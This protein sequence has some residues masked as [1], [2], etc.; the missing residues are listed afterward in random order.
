MNMILHCVTQ[1]VGK[2]HQTKTRARSTRLGLEENQ[3]ANL[4]PPYVCPKLQVQAT[5]Y[6]QHLWLRNWFRF[7]FFK[8]PSSLETGSTNSVRI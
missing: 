5:F 7:P 8:K 2:N 4:D 3:K 1:S 6:C